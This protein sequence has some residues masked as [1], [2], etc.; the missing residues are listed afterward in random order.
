MK[1]VLVADGDLP[2]YP[3]CSRDPDV[4]TTGLRS[5]GHAVTLLRVANAVSWP[6][7]SAPTLQ[8][9]Q[10]TVPAVP[11]YL[12]TDPD[13]VP[14][15]DVVV[16]LGR[17]APPVAAV[18]ADASG[19]PLVVSLPTDLL[20]PA[21]A[22]SAGYSR[23]VCRHLPAACML[24]DFPRHLHAAEQLGADRHKV[25]VVPP[26]MILTAPVTGSPQAP[27]RVL[28]DASRTP[29]PDQQF[30][31]GVLMRLNTRR[32]RTVRT[33]I[34]TSAPCGTACSP[35]RAKRTNGSTSWTTF[36]MKRRCAHT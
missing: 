28:C 27:L 8:L 7:A 33:V 21:R 26:G 10:S 24:V 12:P 35:G 22:V 30:F 2:R 17:A 20:L 4:L 1:I 32:G 5:L 9:A 13:L 16:S 19:S 23:L 6:M 25:F 18:L 11:A 36:S 31:A 3:D 14:P 34:I 29:L 15:A